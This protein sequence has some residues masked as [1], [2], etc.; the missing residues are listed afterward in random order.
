MAKSLVVAKIVF[1]RLPELRGE[2]RRRASALVERTARAVEEDWKSS[3]EG[4]K[5]GR[6]YRRGNVVHQASAPGEAPAIDTG[7]YYGAIHVEMES[8]LTAIV[9]PG[10]A[11]YPV[12][13]ELGGANVAP[14]PAAGPAAEKNRARFE[15][16]AKRLLG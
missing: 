16:D 5:S 11:P 10:A 9:T 15:A 6:L 8:D 4:Q 13:L 12:I 2:L 3:M 7:N 1:D 14:R